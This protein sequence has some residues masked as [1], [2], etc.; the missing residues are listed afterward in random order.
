MDYILLNDNRICLI[1][2]EDSDLKILGWFYHKDY[3]IRKV[4]RE[5]GSRVEVRLHNV[6]LERKL[7]R[8]LKSGYV[9][10][11]ANLNTCDNRRENLREATH[12]QNTANSPAIG[13]ASLYRGVTFSKDRKR[14]KRWTTTVWKNGRKVFAKRY[15]TEEEAARVYDEKAKLVHGEFARLNFPEQSPTDS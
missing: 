9:P 12:S 4:T 7:G 11:H 2:D 5:D 6:I 3:V 13:K 10:D 1:D 14:R 8:P 15:E